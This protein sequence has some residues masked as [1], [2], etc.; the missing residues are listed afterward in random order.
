MPIKIDSNHFS[1]YALLS[2]KMKQPMT[3][4]PPRGNFNV[5]IKPIQFDRIMVPLFKVLGAKCLVCIYKAHNEHIS[6]GWIEVHIVWTLRAF[7]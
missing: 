6:L 7:D 4:D 1:Y 3:N 5:I 2:F